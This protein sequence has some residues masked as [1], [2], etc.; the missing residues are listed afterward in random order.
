MLN[1]RVRRAAGPVGVVLWALAMG[2]GAGHAQGVMAPVPPVDE[3]GALRSRIIQP[4][5]TDQNFCPGTLEP[6]VAGGVIRCGTPNM[7]APYG[8][9]AA[10][11]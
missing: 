8:A 2:A 1:F 6:V 3:G 11:R 9:P 10:R 5:A 4:F 7:A